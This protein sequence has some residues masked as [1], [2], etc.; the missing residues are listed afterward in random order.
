MDDVITE[1]KKIQE[2]FFSEGIPRLWC[3]ILTHYTDEGKIDRERMKKHIDYLRPYVSSF[4]APGSTG[5]GWEMDAEESKG[6]LDFLL[7]EAKK[8]DFWIMVGV[9]RTGM[10]KALDSIQNTVDRLLDSENVTIQ[11]F[12]DNRICGFTVTPPKGSDLLQEEIYLELEKILET[13]Y[14]VSLYQLPQVTENEMTPETVKK[15]ADKYANFYFLKDTSGEDRVVL[16][17]VG[18]QVFM[19]R[20][21]EGDYA[22]WINGND[23]KYDGLLLSTANCFAS[24]LSQIIKKIERGKEEAAV[25][26]SERI[27]TVINKVFKLVEDLPYGNK[28]TNANKLIDHHY[29]YGREALEV[30]P[31]MTHSGNRLSKESIKKTGEILAEYDLLHDN[32]YLE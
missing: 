15:L 4:L 6:L 20:G 18:R 23:G 29:A 24:E 30:E 31:P 17:N 2:K 5:D 25:R 14:P 1:R 26:L 12:V 11:D 9:L 10:G 13:G 27:T 3:P 22:R 21:A 32:G 8:K 28:F 7:K 19:V 16:S